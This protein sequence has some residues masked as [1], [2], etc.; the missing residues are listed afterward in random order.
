[1]GLFA[2]HFQLQAHPLP[3]ARSRRLNSCASGKTA[4]LAINGRDNRRCACVL[5]ANGQF[6]EVFDIDAEGDDDEEEEENTHTQD[7]A[8]DEGVGNG[9]ED[10]M[11]E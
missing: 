6:G 9:Q 1:M 4:T 5:N 8:A 10:T 2:S 7:A 11:E 3:I